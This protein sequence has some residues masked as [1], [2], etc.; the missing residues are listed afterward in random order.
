MKCRERS[1]HNLDNNK[2]MCIHSITEVE[3]MSTE[4]A[5]EAYYKGQKRKQMALL[6]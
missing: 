2:Y 3:V 1:E 5:F 6:L 4:E